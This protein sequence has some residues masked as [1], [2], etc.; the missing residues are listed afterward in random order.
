M[1]V[2]MPKKVGEVAAVEVRRMAS[3]TGFHAVG[4]VPGLHLRVDGE[5]RSA[6]WVLRVMVAG[7]RR[8]MGLGGFPEVSL[9][10]ARRTASDMRGVIRQGRDPI[11]ER[12]AARSAALAE[13][14]SAITFDEAAAAPRWIA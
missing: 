4:G 2:E 10:R 3:R 1:E 7:K 12:E 13:R 5:G 8:D 9:E 14:L 11:A 6:Y